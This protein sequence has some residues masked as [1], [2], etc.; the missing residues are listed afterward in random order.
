MDERQ[1]RALSALVEHL[2]PSD[3]EGISP[4]FARAFEIA[5]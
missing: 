4:A 3:P 5:M 1:D 2:V